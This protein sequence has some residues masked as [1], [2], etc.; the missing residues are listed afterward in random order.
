MEEFILTH[1][2]EITGALFGLLYLYFEYKADI[3]MWATGILMSVFYV[4]VYVTAGFYAFAGINIYYI[5]AQVY[6]WYK[7]NNK[8]VK[9]NKDERPISHTPVKYYLPL[10]AAT[11]VLFLLIVFLLKFYNESSIV[12]G[13]S[14][15]T[16]LGIVAI[17]M[18][19]QKYVEQWLPLIV[20]NVASIFIFYHQG[21]YP[22]SI[23][24]IVY[25]IVSVFGY[26]NWRKMVVS[27]SKLA[28]K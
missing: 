21:L 11:L 28:S 2:Q 6:G 9:D 7:W 14:F 4:Y 26:F 23:L 12:W 15:I 13:D 27:Q 20:A 24:Y 22:T 18:L 17:W 19:T 16:S 1:W 5:L 25:S 8:D 10:S 3:K